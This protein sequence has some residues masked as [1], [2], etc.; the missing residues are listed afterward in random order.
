MT[1][2]REECWW[3]CETQV[4]TG[5]VSGAEFLL[6]PTC[7]SDC[8]PAD[9]C[10]SSLLA[11]YQVAGGVC[12]GSYA[13]V[14][15]PGLFP[16]SDQPCE[17]NDYGVVRG[18]CSERTKELLGDRE[19]CGHPMLRGKQSLFATILLLTRSMCDCQT[20]I[21]FFHGGGYY[22]G[23]HQC[24]PQVAEDVRLIPIEDAYTDDYY[25]VPVGRVPPLENTKHRYPWIC[26]LRIVGQQSSHICAATLLSRPPGPTVLVTSAHCAYI[27]KSEEGNIVPNCCCPNVGPGLCTDTQDCGTNARTLLITGADAEV[28]CG[29]WDTATDTEEDYNVILPIEK[30]TVHPD[31]NISRGEEN[32]QFVA[33][34]I[35]TIHVND[36]NFEQQS[37]THNIHPACLPSPNNNLNSTAVHSGWS[38]PPPLDYVTNHAPNHEAYYGGFSKQW[39]YSLNI[40][41]CEDPKTYPPAKWPWIGGGEPMNYP[42]NSYYPPGTICAVEKE[43]KFCPTS[44]ESGSPLMVSDDEGRMVAEGISSFIKVLKIWLLYLFFKVN[45]QGEI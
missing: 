4:S 28:K 23:L 1:G 26:S 35:A 27:C 19:N 25:A 7:L 31:F 18:L 16:V 43:K 34:D 5:S 11:D 24:E 12:S 39:H 44:G 37:R 14:H 20:Y 10:L 41:K 2:G 21:S 6:P 38:K 36:D 30:I 32:S 22:A 13:E 33:D 9:H 15:Y 3:G 8:Y 45:L 29:E 40:T 17:F 42:T